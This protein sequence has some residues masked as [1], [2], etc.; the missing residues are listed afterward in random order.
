MPCQMNESLECSFSS[1][2]LSPLPPSHP[3]I[4]AILPASFFSPL[5]PRSAISPASTREADS[6]S[7][8]FVLRQCL[9][10][11]DPNSLSLILAREPLPAP[12]SLCYCIN[13]FFDPAENVRHSWH[14]VYAQNV[15]VERTYSTTLIDSFYKHFLRAS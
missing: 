2:R 14:R 12:V 3:A 1:K 5:Y 4:S 15:C 13:A 8:C 10:T 6:D 7:S 9:F 11:L